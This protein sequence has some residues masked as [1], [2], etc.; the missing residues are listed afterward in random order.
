MERKKRT[1]EKQ[2]AYH[3]RGVVYD[4]ILELHLDSIYKTAVAA[5]SCPAG[6]TDA[7]PALIM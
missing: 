6:V 1:D 4:D 7:A 2:C 5:A 3:K